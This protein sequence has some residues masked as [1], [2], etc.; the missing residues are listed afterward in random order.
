M[1]AGSS[2]SPAKVPPQP[3]VSRGAVA[4]TWRAVVTGLL[5]Y[6]A[7][8]LAFFRTGLHAWIAKPASSAG[9]TARRCLYES[10]LRPLDERPSILLLGDSTM[11]DCCAPQLLQERIGTPDLV[12]R[13]AAI[14]GTG[15]MVWPFVV[16][17]I[18]PPNRRTLVVVGV[19][20]FYED[21]SL[22]APGG[23]AEDLAFLPLL[24]GIADAPDIAA[25]MP[26]G[27]L[28]HDAWL[29]LLSKT[30]AWRRDIR[31]LL[32]AP[33][34]RYQQV[35]DMFRQLRWGAPYA[36]RPGDLVGA[37]V[38]AGRVVLPFEAPQIAAQLQQVVFAPR[39]SHPGHERLWFGRLASVTAALG[40]QLVVVR[41]P[42][43]V[44]PRADGAAGRPRAIFGELAGRSQV[45]VL[46]PALFADLERPEYFYDALHMNRLGRQR[47]TE[48][49]ADT[50]RQ[51]FGAVLTR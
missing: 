11:G 33:L 15:P 9:W 45:H 5:L 51:R 24:A 39:I 30:Y 17:A 12:V 50:L 4:T 1:S 42:T 21:L 16:A 48:R 13:D 2:S 35:R 23:S 41:V 32:V 25:S 26:A 34:E 20:S 18:A 6:L 3:D 38:E 22:E 31:D 43:Q 14:P 19:T 49:L 37:R 46:D 8:E 36:G 47:F 7:V 29:Q 27:A 40:G 10:M 28:R 44:L